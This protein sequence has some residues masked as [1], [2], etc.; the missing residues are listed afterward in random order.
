MIVDRIEFASEY[1]DRLPHLA[2]AIAYISEHPAPGEGKHYFPGGYL[3]YQ[4][5]MTR[6]LSDGV[7][8]AHRKY[9]D[10]QMLI[11]GDEFYLWNRLEKMQE[12]AAYDPEKDKH[13]IDGEG[14]LLELKAG[15]FAVFFPNDAHKACR[16][17]DGQEPS[18]YTKYVVKLEL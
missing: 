9:I 16:H 11:E 7:Y 4:T 5:G 12:T 6:A 10:V 15:M 3:M 1:S 14:S 13:A 8:E 18:A 2:D 17:L